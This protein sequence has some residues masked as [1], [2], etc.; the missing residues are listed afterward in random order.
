M[1]EEWFYHKT[2]RSYVCDVNKHTFT[3]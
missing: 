2:H 3:F 1:R